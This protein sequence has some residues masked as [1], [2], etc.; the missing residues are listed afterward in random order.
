MAV[1]V[2]GAYPAFA[3]ITNW[4]SGIWLDAN[5][6]K[7]FVCDTEAELPN[8]AVVSEGSQVYCKD[9]HHTYIQTAGAWVDPTPIALPYSALTGVPSTF[10]P[11]I[12]GGATQA[13]AGND[14]RLS[15]ARTPTTH[16]ASHKTGGSDTIKLDEFA[17]PTDVTTLNASTS[18]HGLMQK[19]PGGTTT[20][21]RADGAFATPAG[22]GG[23][24]VITTATLAM[25]YAS[26]L[27]RITVV[28]A[29]VS[30]SSKIL[31]SAAGIPETSENSGDA[32]ECLAL[33]A[34]PG[35]G[36]FEVCASFM[37]PVGGSFPVNYTIG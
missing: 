9:T 8:P 33:T 22:G 14:S 29:N 1:A 31:L 11:I 37:T 17:A 16:A 21:L 12:G 5:A 15:D 3:V 26:R 18:A 6:L 2:Y 19:Y 20:F 25:P 35:A 36:S 34:I 13:C 27:Q 7:W 24:A 10:A 28:D 4:T 30:G 32:V 23:S